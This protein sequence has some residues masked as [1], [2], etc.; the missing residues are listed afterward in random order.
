MKTFILFFITALAEISGCFAPYAVL[1]QGRHPLWLLAGAAAL[2]LF[3]WLLTL[4][5]AE[6][7]GSIYAAYGGV[8]IVASLRWLW[9]VEGLVPDRFD[10][11]GAFFCRLGAGV[12]ML[13]PRT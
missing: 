5:T 10:I 2:A 11:T 9:R 13:A 4:H 6:G 12:I 1:R 3:A 7:A 8:Y